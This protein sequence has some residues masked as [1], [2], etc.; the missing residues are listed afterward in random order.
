MIK[1]LLLLLLLLLLCV[2]GDAALGAN[3]EAVEVAFAA[4]DVSTSA[5]CGLLDTGPAVAQVSALEQA[6][7]GTDGG[8]AFSSKAMTPRKGVGDML[9]L[10]LRFSFSSV[11]DDIALCSCVMITPDEWMDGRRGRR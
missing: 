3:E 2:R 5:S 8:S 1:P 9:R 11:D 6:T 4:V 10:P 7:P